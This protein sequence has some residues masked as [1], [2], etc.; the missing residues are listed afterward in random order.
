MRCTCRTRCSRWRA[1][2]AWRPISSSPA[3]ASRCAAG[4]NWPPRQAFD[5]N[6]RGLFDAQALAA[7]GIH[8]EDRHGTQRFFPCTTL[9]I[10]AVR[11]RPGMFSEA[12]AVASAAA[13]AKRN[14]KA[15]ERG[16]HVVG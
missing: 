5:D 8:A 7:G 12:D 2:K 9:C 11:V 1:R 16:L 14:A 3:C 15:S 10:G 13:S 6:A 4:R